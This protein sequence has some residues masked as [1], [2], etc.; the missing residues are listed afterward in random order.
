MLLLLLCRYLKYV[1]KND[2]CD[3]IGGNGIAL[4][5]DR[6]TLNKRYGQTELSDRTWNRPDLSEPK[7]RTES[8]TSHVLRVVFDAVFEVRR[9]NRRTKS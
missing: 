2:L 4:Y 1:T 8:I 9:T 7:Y 6:D 3:K 5:R